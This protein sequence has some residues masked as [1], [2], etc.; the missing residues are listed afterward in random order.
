MANSDT[1]ELLESI[2]NR[3]KWLLQL[4][5]EEQ[6]EE[7]AT[8]REKVKMLSRMGFDNHEMAEVVGTSEA[9]IRGTL[10]DLRQ[11]GEID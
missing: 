5:V 11:D 3:L 7:G 8:N 2:D 9:S 10:S 6:F 4:R 1:N